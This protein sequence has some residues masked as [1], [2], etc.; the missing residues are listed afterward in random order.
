MS[1]T[2]SVNLIWAQGINGVIGAEQAIPWHLPEDLANFQRL[3]RG[4][5]VIMGRRTWD[6]LPASV[7]PL[8]G[9]TNIVL[10][11]VRSWGAAGAFAAA[12]LEEALAAAGASVFIIGGGEIYRQALPLASRAYVTRVD[13]APDGDT[14]VPELEGWRAQHGPWLQSAGGLRYRYEEHTPPA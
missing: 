2:Q 3:T 11:R 9:R 1:G 8:P 7:R 10:T 5:A 12:S 6:S 4:S 13:A 14:S